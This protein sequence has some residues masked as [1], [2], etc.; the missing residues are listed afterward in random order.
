MVICTG[1]CGDHEWVG[2][3]DD[4]PECEESDDRRKAQICIGQ[5][6]A[7]GDYGRGTVVAVFGDQAQVMWDKP[8]LVGTTNRLFT[9]DRI[10]VERLTRLHPNEGE[11]PGA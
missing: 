2:L 10:F 7:S 6:V 5:R 8:M 3:P 1:T 9:H 11:S 4:E